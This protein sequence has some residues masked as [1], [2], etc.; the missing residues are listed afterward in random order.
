MSTP[1][2][3]LSLALVGPG[4]VGVAI[5]LLLKE[6]GHRVIRAV[7][8]SSTSLDRAAH[9]LDCEVTTDLTGATEE[10]DAIMIAVSDDEI[11]PI[12]AR[13]AEVAQVDGKVF[14]HTAGALGQ[15]PLSPLALLGGRTAAIHVLQ[16]IPDVEAGVER[17]PGSWF[18]VTCDESLRE[19]CAEL[20]SDLQGHVLWVDESR[21]G[22]YHAAAVIAS[23]FMVALGGLVE[24]VGGDLAP[25]LPLMAGTLR[26]IEEFGPLAAL[27]G[28]AVRGDEGTIRDHLSALRDDPSA[29][30][31]YVALTLTVLELAMKGNRI[32]QQ[33]YASMVEVLK[34]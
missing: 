1:D 23:N 31:A 33:R 34:S 10:A 16:A 30:Q 24:T 21:R 18:G 13:L 25:Y 2:R 6:R 19:W 29:G 3:S 12:A 32:S 20:V 9:N 11:A 14:F 4:R 26:N 22:A 5:A 28:P 17:I 15:A 7:G 27:T 8:R